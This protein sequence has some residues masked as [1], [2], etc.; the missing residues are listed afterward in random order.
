MI[1]EQIFPLIVRGGARPRLWLALRG[2]FSKQFLPCS[3]RD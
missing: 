1:N 2:A 3:D